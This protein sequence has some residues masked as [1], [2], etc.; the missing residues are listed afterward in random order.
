M[1]TYS[2]LNMSQLYRQSEFNNNIART[3][4]IGNVMNLDEL[5]INDKFTR[6]NTYPS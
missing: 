3:F 2:Y 6:I 1:S 4:Q 5:N